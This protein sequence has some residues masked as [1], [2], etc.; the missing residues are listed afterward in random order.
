MQ[1]QRPGLRKINN[2]DGWNGLKPVFDGQYQMRP[3]YIHV[4]YYNA[5]RIKKVVTLT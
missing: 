5:E 2:Q 1:V 4:P 3:A